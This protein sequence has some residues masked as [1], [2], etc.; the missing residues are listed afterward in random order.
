MELKTQKVYYFLFLF[1]YIKYINLNRIQIV[2]PMFEQIF[3]VYTS[4]RTSSTF[5][6]LKWQAKEEEYED[7]LWNIIVFL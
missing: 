3:W 1:I 7:I 2:M 4:K 6:D 5:R